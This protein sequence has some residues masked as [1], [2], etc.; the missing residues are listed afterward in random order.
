MSDSILVRVRRDRF[1]LMTTGRQTQVYVQIP[2]VGRASW[3]LDED[4]FNGL[5]DKPWPNVVDIAHEC[6]PRGAD[7][8]TSAADARLAVVRWLRDDA[9]RDEMQAAYE[10]HEARRHPVARKLLDEIERLRTRLA[11]LESEHPVMF[12][13][14]LD[15]IPLGY[16]TSPSEARKHCETNVRRQ[17]PEGSILSLSWWTEDVADDCATY[18]LHVTPSEVGEL[19]RG[20]GYV[21][22]PIEVSAKYEAGDDE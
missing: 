15:S 1:D 2:E 7:V 10:E 19:I 4:L 3:L 13:A 16:Y 18:E 6:Q 8:D 14:D 20:T 21:V 5:A 17:A 9:N 11:E 12:R 22:T